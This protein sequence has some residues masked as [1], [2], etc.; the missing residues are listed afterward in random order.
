MRDEPVA[1]VVERLASAGQLPSR[2]R[3]RPTRERAAACDEPVVIDAADVP[4][5]EQTRPGGIARHELAE[6]L[7]AARRGAGLREQVELTGSGRPAI[8]TRSHSS[9]ALRRRPRW[10]PAA[11]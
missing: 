9:V 6:A 7:V 8:A 11:R 10:R 3:P 4:G 2:E 1:D 5:D